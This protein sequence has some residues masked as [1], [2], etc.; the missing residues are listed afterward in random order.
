M[1]NKILIIIVILVILA[2]GIGMGIGIGI[3]L[4]KGGEKTDCGSAYGPE[5]EEGGSLLEKNDF[6][7]VMPE[8]WAEMAAPTGVSAMVVN[9]NEEV[10]EPEA[11]KI[12][13]QTYYSVV[14]DTLNERSKEEYFQSIAV[15]LSQTVPGVVIVQEQEERIDNQD[16]Y[17]VEAEFNQRNIDF[18]ILL[19]I[20]TGEGEGVWIL[21]FNGLKSAWNDY[22][23][24]FYE[25]ARSFKLR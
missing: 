6:F 7:V 3:Y 2:A 25:I 19:V 20:F 14:Y 24:L 17:F 9:V 22:K 16:A 21:T 23:D 4:S 5:A 1:K 12:N 11:Q 18:K 15:S 8:G 13:F 10:T